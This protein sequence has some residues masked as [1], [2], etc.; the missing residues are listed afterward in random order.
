[1]FMG[2]GT[3]NFLPVLHIV[4]FIDY[5]TMN[6]QSTRTRRGR[7]DPE[8]LNRFKIQVIFRNSFVNTVFVI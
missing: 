4:F 2:Y 5:V 6:I 8:S 1:M 7:M 3:H